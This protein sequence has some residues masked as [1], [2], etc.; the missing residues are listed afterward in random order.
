MSNI[1]NSAFD[2]SVI[3]PM[4]GQKGEL[5]FEA[6]VHAESIS[7]AVKKLRD[8]VAGSG[9]VVVQSAALHLKPQEPEVHE[10]PEP[11]QESV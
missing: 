10:V 3:K 4:K 5:M 8:Q 2:L 1:Q 6:K 7:S 9:W 11:M